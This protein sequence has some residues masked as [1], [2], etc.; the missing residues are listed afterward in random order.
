M[1]VFKDNWIFN[2]ERVLIPNPFLGRHL[3]KRD[4]SKL[5]CVAFSTKQTRFLFFDLSIMILSESEGVIPFFFL[6]I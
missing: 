4:D 1:T 3:L 6:K 5:F 2:K